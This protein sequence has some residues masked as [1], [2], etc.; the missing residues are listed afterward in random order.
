VRATGGPKPVREP[1]EV[2]FIV[3]VQDCD[4]RLLDDLVLQAGYP[5]GALSSILLGNI[6]SL[7]RLRS[8][9][10]PVHPGVEVD[11]PL[12]QS[13]SVLLPRHSIHSGR[14]L[15][16][17]LVVAVPQQR[18]RDVVQQGGEPYLLILACYLSYTVQSTKRGEPALRPGRGGLADVLPGRSPSLQSLPRRLPR[19]VRSLRRYCA[20]VR[21]P[22]NVH[23]RLLAH[24]LLRPARPSSATGVAGVSRFSRLEFPCMLRVSDPAE[25][26]IDMSVRLPRCGLPPTEKTSAPWRI[27]KFRGSI[28][29]LHVPLSTLH[30]HPHGCWRMT[31]GQGGSLVL[32]CEA[33]SSSTPSRFSPALSPV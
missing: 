23:V 8:I 17:Q 25:P 1:L 20:T 5:Q 32:P 3:A 19:G 18:N 24:G 9:G 29:G 31:R 11:Q 28:P 7:R 21:L 27:N 14:S 22:C 13:P 2:L 30:P 12:L 10:A 33:L 26:G 6:G 16:L 15:L 4:Q